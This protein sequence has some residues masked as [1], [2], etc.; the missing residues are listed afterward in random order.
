MFDLFARAGFA[1]SHILIHSDFHLDIYSPKLQDQLQETTQKL[2]EGHESNATLL[3]SHPELVQ[4]PL[5]PSPSETTDMTQGHLSILLEL[6]HE[7][8]ELG[9][10]NVLF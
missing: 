10:L 7:L 5:M 2:P 1:N 6:R 8:R 4:V 9:F 3:L